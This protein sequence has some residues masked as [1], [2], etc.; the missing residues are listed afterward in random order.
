MLSTLPLTFV[1]IVDSGSIT[2]AADE[3]NLAKS[4]VSQNLKRLEQQLDIKLAT[5]STRRFSL[6]PAGERYY[7]RCKEVL[8]LSKL[9]ETELEAYGSK[10]SGPFTIT[11]PHALIAPVVA[12]AMTTVSRRF[13]RS[14]TGDNCRGQASGFDCR[15]DRRFH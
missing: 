8:M 14:G 11:A 6:T 15:W 9:A 5:R 4:A 2:R 13:P 3:L 1:T 12:P 7:Q 10:P